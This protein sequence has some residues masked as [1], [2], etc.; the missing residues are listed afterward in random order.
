MFIPIR[1]CQ[2]ARPHGW[3]TYEEEF[4]S[5]FLQDYI[6]ATLEPS[7]YLLHPVISVQ[8]QDDT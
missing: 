6:E 7:R 2:H 3:N 8:E 5:Q 4:S 1:S